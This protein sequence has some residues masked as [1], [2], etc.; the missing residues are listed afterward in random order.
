MRRFWPNPDDDREP[1]G[2][3]SVV[4]EDIAIFEARFFDGTEWSYEW[5]EDMNTLPLLIELNI[6][7]VQEGS[8]QPAITPSSGRT[9]AQSRRSASIPG[10]CVGSGL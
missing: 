8:R 6:V 3:L 10:G 2:I 9:S 4:A 1:G 7:A 5:P